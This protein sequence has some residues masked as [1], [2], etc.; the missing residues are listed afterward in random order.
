[1]LMKNSLL[2]LYLLA[3]SAVTAAESTMPAFF[4]VSY[5]LYSN[6]TKIGLM[7]REFSMQDENNYVFRSESKTTG[8]I[9]LFR[10]DHIIEQSNWKFVE[11]RFIPQHYSYQHTG[12]KKDRFVEISFNWDKKQIINQV[13]D[14]TWFMETQVGILDKLLYQLTI[15]SDLK[16]GQVPDI[17]TIADGGKIKNYYFEYLGD[18]VVETPLGPLKTMKIERRKSNS[19]RKTWLWCAYDYHFMPVKVVITE[20]KG[21]LTTALI[22]QLNG[23]EPKNY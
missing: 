12:G 17:Y 6:D 13:N 1:M 15:M 10:K 9:S 20:K 21:R 3:A 5:T 18:E 8:F 4:D 11:N 2:L 7:K 23:I 22:K 16:T 19:K 14:S